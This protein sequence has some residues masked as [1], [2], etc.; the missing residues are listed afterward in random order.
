MARAIKNKKNNKNNYPKEEMP[1]DVFAVV[2]KTP[3]GKKEYVAWKKAKDAAQEYFTIVKKKKGEGPGRTKKKITYTWNP[4]QGVHKKIVEKKGKQKEKII[5]HSKFAK[6]REKISE[7]VVHGTKKT[8]QKHKNMAEGGKISKPSLIK[9][10]KKGSNKSQHSKS[11]TL[12]KVKIIKSEGGKTTYGTE[13][14]KK[15]L[16]TPPKPKKKDLGSLY[17]TYDSFAEGGKMPA[18]GKKRKN[19]KLKKFFKKIFKRKCKNGNCPSFKHGGKMK[20]TC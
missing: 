6:K 1:K 17:G 5:G 14:Q 19:G 7:K 9:M 15:K 10:R 2:S 8:K 18:P 20:C 3:S 12:E 16:N 13:S 4:E 11:P